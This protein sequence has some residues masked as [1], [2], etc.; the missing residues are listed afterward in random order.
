MEIRKYDPTLDE[1]IVAPMMEQY[2]LEWDRRVVDQDYNARK[3][4]LG[5]LKRWWDVYVIVD[6]QDT[7]IWF[8][9]WEK[10]PDRETTY[11]SSGAYIVPHLRER[12]Y[13]TELKKHQESIARDQWCRIVQSIIRFWNEL[14]LALAKKQWYDYEYNIANQ[15]YDIFKFL[16]DDTID[17]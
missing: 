15:R 13:W 7:V 4:I 3:E 1:E 16:S 5:L 14:W 12:G 10:R 11:W 17:E 2:F 9:R 8:H 6:G